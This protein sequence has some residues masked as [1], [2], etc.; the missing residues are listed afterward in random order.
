MS[1]PPPRA[2]RRGSTRLA[3]SRRARVRSSLP[4]RDA[5]CPCL[6]FLH[7]G[8]NSWQC[9]I[10]RRL[11]AMSMFCAD[12]CCARMLAP[13]LPLQARPSQAN[14]SN[15]CRFHSS[16]SSSSQ[17]WR[18]RWW[19]ALLP[20][21][22]LP[23]RAWVRTQGSCHPRTSPAPAPVPHASPL[24]SKLHKLDSGDASFLVRCRTLVSFL[25]AC[26]LCRR[27]GASAARD[28]AAADA[29]PLPV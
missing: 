6:L 20:P 9:A 2:R 8:G 12:L 4:G 11:V 7:A 15:Q 21:T 13:V 18:P 22:S 25:P 24:S 16:S 27:R 5:T 10:S 17:Q 19:A 23:W 14:V 3:A 26:C 29:V 28:G 1:S